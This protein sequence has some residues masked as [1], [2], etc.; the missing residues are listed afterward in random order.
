MKRISNCIGHGSYLTASN[1]NPSKG[2][3]LQSTGAE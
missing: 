2:I 3:V 1:K